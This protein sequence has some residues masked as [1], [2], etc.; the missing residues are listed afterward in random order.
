MNKP[1]I[2]YDTGSKWR[3]HLMINEKGEVTMDKMKPYYDDKTSSKVFYEVDPIKEQL[4]IDAI[5]ERMREIGVAPGDKTKITTFNKEGYPTYV[6]KSIKHFIDGSLRHALYDSYA[7]YSSYHLKPWETSFD[8]LLYFIRYTMPKSAFVHKSSDWNPSEY[9]LTVEKPI[10]RRALGN[11]RKNSFDFIE[12]EMVVR[13][14]DA[15]KERVLDNKD[16][17]FNK[18]IA[19]IERDKSFKKFGVPIGILKM[20]QFSIHKGGILRIN[21]CL[22][23]ELVKGETL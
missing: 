1:V 12:I 14:N 2:I 4:L 9:V 17:I 19:A 16:E 10:Y 3:P 23:D 7:H 11:T 5:T 15:T 21:F 13:S 6:G 20:Y 18:A 8:D 22:K